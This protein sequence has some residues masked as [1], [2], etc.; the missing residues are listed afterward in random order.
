MVNINEKKLDYFFNES[1]L[2]RCIRKIYDL[3]QQ[4]F[5]QLLGYSQSALSKIENGLISPDLKFIVSLSQKLKIDLNI[6]RFGHI[7]RLSNNQLKSNIDKS[8][9]S[10]KYLKDG[11]ISAKTTYFLMELLNNNYKKDIYS[12][13]GINEET[14]CLSFLKYNMK[15]FEKLSEF[16]SFTD[17]LKVMHQYKPE[18]CG[19]YNES[20]FKSHL[21]DNKILTLTKLLHTKGGYKFSLKIRDDFKS[22][23]KQY[24]LSVLYFD[25]LVTFNIPMEL[26]TLSKSKDSDCEITVYACA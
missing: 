8:F 24:L 10:K 16:V 26:E 7:P 20:N 11:I 21:L 2:I 5:C 14:F 22:S 1:V 12:A 23:N 6:F 9:V 17:I 15:F 25:L 13:M 3:S 19:V 4:D 18:E